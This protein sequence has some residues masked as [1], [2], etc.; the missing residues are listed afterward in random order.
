[1]AAALNS[2]SL[3]S[4]DSA[5][6][7][8][9]TNS[10]DKAKWSPSGGSQAGANAGASGFGGSSNAFAAQVRQEHAADSERPC[11]LEE[12]WQNKVKAVSVGVCLFLVVHL[13]LCWQ[14][15]LVSIVIQG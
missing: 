13:Y 1:M 6:T 5:E 9:S 14:M 15:H 2:R 4:T 8:D 11:C 10:A 12:F 3:M 7:V